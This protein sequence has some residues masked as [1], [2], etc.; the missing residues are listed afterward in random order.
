[1]DVFRSEIALSALAWNHGCGDRFRRPGLP[2]SQRCLP[3]TILCGTGLVQ[4]YRVGYRVRM[5]W[6]EIRGLV[7]G[8][9]HA[10]ENGDKYECTV[11]V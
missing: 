4:V 8:D 11:A 5:F 6:Y 10:R 3:T 2:V 9:Q 1:M 7:T